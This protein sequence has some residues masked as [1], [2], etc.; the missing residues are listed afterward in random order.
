MHKGH[1]FTPLRYPGGKTSLFGYFSDVIGTNNWHDTVYIEPYAGGAGAALSLLCMERVSSIVI[2]DFDPAVYA[3][4]ISATQDTKRLVNLIEK[5]PVNMKMWYEQREIYRTA[6]LSD[7][8]SLGFA[9]FFL[10]RTNRSGILNAGVIG[11]KAQS[12]EWKLDARYNKGS[13]I[14]KIETIGYFRKRISVLNE[15]GMEVVKQ[16]SNYENSFFYIDP[17]YYVKGSGLYLNSFSPSDHKNLASLLNLKNNTNWI[18]SYDNVDE[19]SSMYTER[20]SL[21]FNLTYSAN[22]NS[23]NGSE[24]MVFSDSVL[25][26]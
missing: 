10:N 2:N 4:W 3:F 17:P 26:P 9:T 8:L 15:D 21:V 7:P 23:K 22:H 19:I 1:S 11:G 14:K 18:L 16:Y 13:L 24:L 25:I 12:G 6:D 5:T 20:R